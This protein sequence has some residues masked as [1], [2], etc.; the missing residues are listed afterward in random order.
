MP[1][2]LVVDDE[3][4]IRDILERFF[5]KKKY[6]VLTSESGEE[7]ISLLEKEKIDAVLLDIRMPGMNGLDALRSMLKLRPDMPVIMVTGETDEEIAKSSLR[8]GAF[9]YVMKPLN[10][11]YLERTLHLKLAQK[12]L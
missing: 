10:F 5:T 9:D 11:D 6:E 1:R 3:K 7:A 12:L 2:I 8:E 4:D